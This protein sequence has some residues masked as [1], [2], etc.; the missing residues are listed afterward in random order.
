MPLASFSKS[1][2]HGLYKGRGA[3][4]ADEISGVSAAAVLETV[5]LVGGI[6]GLLTTVF[7]IWD[8]WARGAGT[9]DYQGCERRRLFQEITWPLTGAP[10]RPQGKR[11]APRAGRPFRR[12]LRGITAIQSP[13]SKTVP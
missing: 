12:A 1:C 8:R 2:G 13:A 6:A 11:N 5:K 7:V 9:V 4:V 3:A 10:N